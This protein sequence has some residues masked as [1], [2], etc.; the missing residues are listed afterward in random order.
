MSTP[1]METHIKYESTL[2][3]IMFIKCAYGV[4]LDSNKDAVSSKA[5]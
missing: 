5:I 3:T 2:S 1:V 4:G